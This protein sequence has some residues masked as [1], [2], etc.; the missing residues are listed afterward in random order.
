MAQLIKVHKNP[1]LGISAD[2]MALFQEVRPPIKSRHSLDMVERVTRWLPLMQST[3]PFPPA[4]QIK[5]VDT[6]SVN[7]HACACV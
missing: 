3:T 6:D 1:T 2:T 5:D 4:C 7:Q